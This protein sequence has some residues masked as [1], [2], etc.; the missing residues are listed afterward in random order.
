MPLRYGWTKPGYARLMH[1]VHHRPVS[2]LPAWR[3]R[4]PPNPFGLVNAADGDYVQHLGI[5]GTNFLSAWPPWRALLAD[6]RLN[7]LLQGELGVRRLWTH[8]RAGRRVAD[9]GLTL[10]VDYG[11]CGLN[12]L[13]HML[14]HGVYTRTQWMLWHLEQITR[15]WYAPQ[16][17]E[18]P[19]QHY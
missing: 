19:L 5:A 6:W 9:D 4:F 11:P 12:F 10:L 8:L 15:C 1:F 18:L 7:R 17:D 14:G 2:R 16:S 13:A 3:A